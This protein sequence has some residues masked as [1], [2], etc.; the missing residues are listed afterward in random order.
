MYHVHAVLSE[1]L[2]LYTEIEPVDTKSSLQRIK[3]LPI[4]YYK[5][6][7]DSVPDR[8]QL[9]VVGPEAQRLFPESI[10]VLPSTAFATRS[11]SGDPVLPVPATAVLTNLPVVD[12]NVLFMHGIA[13]VKELIYIYEKLNSTVQ[14]LSEIDRDTELKYENLRAG[15]NK[16]ISRLQTEKLRI[17]QEELA[18]AKKALQQEEKRA[19]LEEQRVQAQLL[20]ERSLLEFEEKLSKDR[21]LQQEELS[22][23][24]LNK[25]LKLERELAERK[26]A[27]QR[28]SAE[29]MQTL[30][31]NQNKELEDRRLLLEKEKIKA[32]IEAK[33]QQDRL[34]EEAAMRKLEMQSKL[35]TERMVQGIKSVSTQVS[36]IVKDVFSRPKQVAMIAGILLGILACYYIIREFSAMV[37]EFIQ[38]RIGKPSLVRETSYHLSIWPDFLRLSFYLEGSKLSERMRKLEDQFRDIILCAQDK[39]RVINLAY[40][41]RNTRRSDAP[42]RHVLLHGPPGTGKTLIARRLAECSGMDYAI[43]SG[44]DVAPLGE[45]A[46]NQLHALFLWAS[47]SKKGLLVFIDE[48]EAFLS[49]RSHALGEGN[50]DAHLRNAL[51]ALLYQTGT[52]SKHFMMVLATN[53]PVDLD[54]AI[55]DR[56]DVSLQI[57]L[58]GEAQRVDLIKQYM[59]VHLSTVA[60]ASQRK[61]LSMLLFG[62]TG[63]SEVSEECST[64]DSTTFM[65]KVTDGFSGREISKLFI[66]AQYAM[67]LSPDRVLTWQSLKKVVLEKVGDHQVKVTGFHQPRAPAAFPEEMAERTD[68]STTNKS[69]KGSRKE[70][71]QQQ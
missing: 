48:A 2:I 47:R 21:L 7:F 4:V 16:D 64:T 5:F 23:E 49:S 71:M 66:S 69:K 42:F 11:R 20:N 58:P 18:L 52:P 17:A 28:R 36:T 10:D 67:Y 43:L 8:I 39:E 50:A 37:R 41:T 27:L 62:K 34:N 32:E 57:G 61:G 9:G 60:L 13:A 19:E 15:F 31:I 25:Q 55:L 33:T 29:S 53:R 38:S 51:N 6:L 35:D 30:K 59:D 24:S 56:V 46:V 22:R 1:D 68:V 26:D 45:D 14:S 3:D 65:A 40:A 63:Q 44:G 54:A 12:K 70:R